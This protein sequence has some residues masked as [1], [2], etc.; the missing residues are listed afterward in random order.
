MPFFERKRIRMHYEIHEGLVDRDTICLHG[1]LASNTWWEPTIEV[2]KRNNLNSASAPKTGRLIC[3][4]WRGCGKSIGLVNEDDLNFPALADDYNGLL[5]E[6]GIRGAAAIGHSTGGLIALFAMRKA[7]ELYSR[8]VL[9][10]PVGATGVQFGPAMYETFAA[11]SKD[12]ELCRAVITATIYQGNPSPELISRIVADAYNVNPLIWHGVPR[13]L[14]PVDFRSEL[15]FIKHPTLVLHGEH[16][17]ILPRVE[18]QTLASAL[19]SGKFIELMGRGHSC[20]IE[21]P[22]LFVAHLDRFLFG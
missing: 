7:P 3:A 17:A 16:D 19:P 18:S 12:I 11:M 9:L 15:P 1:N 21:D 14:S 4:E 20:N 5:R 8:A 2:W 6:L 10:A 22:E 13:M